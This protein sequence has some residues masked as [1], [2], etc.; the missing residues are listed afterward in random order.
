MDDP[1]WAEM[2]DRDHEMYDQMATQLFLRALR[3][4][5][6]GELLYCLFCG[7]TA[8]VQGD[9]TIMMIGADVLGQLKDNS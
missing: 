7:G 5:R 9:G 8:T 1:A 3:S 6:H 2:S 4:E